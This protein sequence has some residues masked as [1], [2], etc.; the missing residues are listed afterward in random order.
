MSRL[1]HNTA[2]T[3]SDKT[4]AGAQ[5]IYFDESGFTGNNLLNLDQPAFVYTSVAI[6]PQNASRLHNELVSRFHLR[7]KELKGK[8]LVRYSRGQEAI[9]WLLNECEDIACIT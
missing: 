1:L 2:G 7:G 5:T 6:D 3:S 4:M 8:N 9:S